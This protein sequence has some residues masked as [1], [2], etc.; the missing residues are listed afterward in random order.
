[1]SQDFLLHEMILQLFKSIQV[2]IFPYLQPEL[3]NRFTNLYHFSWEVFSIYGHS[4]ICGEV[5]LADMAP[6]GLPEDML[7][8]LGRGRYPNLTVRP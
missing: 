4:F 1:M 6:G 3:L 5:E 8:L 2:G 7:M